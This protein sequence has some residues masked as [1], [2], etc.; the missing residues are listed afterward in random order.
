[1][2]EPQCFDLILQVLGERGASGGVALLL[3]FQVLRDVAEA[4]LFAELEV[5]VQR[6]GGSRSEFER[7]GMVIRIESGGLKTRCNGLVPRFCRRRS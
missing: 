2:S 5:E 7:F 4:I 6:F 3:L 1:V